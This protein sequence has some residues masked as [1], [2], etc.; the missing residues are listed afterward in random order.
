MKSKLTAIFAALGMAMLILNTKTALVGANEGIEVCI[1]TVIPSLFP[2]FVL[3]TLLNSALMGQ[4]LGFLAPLAKLLR[5]PEKAMPLIVVGLLGGYPV[6]AQGV[7]SACKAGSLGKKDG[8]RMLAFCSNAGPAFIFGMGARL[9][10][11][12]WVCFL[13]WAIHIVSSWC[14]ALLTPCSSTRNAVFTTGHVVTLP[15]AVR[16][17]VAVLSTVCGWVV[18]FRI[19]IAFGDRWLLWAVTPQTRAVIIGIAE[20]ANGCCML[21]QIARTGLRMSLFAALLSFGGVCVMMQTASVCE[22][23]SMKLY[24]PGKLCQSAISLLLS[25]PA[26]LLLPRE[27]R[28]VCGAAP[29]VICYTIFV[30]YGFFAKKIQKSSSI[31]AKATV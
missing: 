4:R 3:S 21:P 28:W 1:R 24:L 31:R 10:D 5:V 2:F 17:A 20:L 11:K 23:L 6:G 26:Q 19:L 27:E 8:Q 18:L 15:Q 13:I 12:L 16:K 29:M 9:F 30:G 25:I 14:V 7:T 22:E